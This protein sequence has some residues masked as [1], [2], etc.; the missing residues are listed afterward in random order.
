MLMGATGAPG[1]VFDFLLMSLVKK[2]LERLTAN[3]L[4]MSPEKCVWKTQD[5]E[6]LGYIIGKDGIKMS[7]KKWMRYWIGK[8][9]SP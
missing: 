9:R 7:G 6:F 8:R 2:V 4:A 3:G 5:V 1:A